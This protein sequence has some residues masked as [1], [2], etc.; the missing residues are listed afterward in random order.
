MAGGLGQ[1]HS[2]AGVLDTSRCIIGVRW[3]LHH[4]EEMWLLVPEQRPNQ[5]KWMGCRKRLSKAAR[6]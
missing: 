3:L 5:P 4:L 2:G 1:P 6:L